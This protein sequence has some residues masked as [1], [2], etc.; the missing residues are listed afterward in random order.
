MPL[1]L[2]NKMSSITYLCNIISFKDSKKIGLKA[3]TC[4]GKSLG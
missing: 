2:F 3:K 4:R 1:P